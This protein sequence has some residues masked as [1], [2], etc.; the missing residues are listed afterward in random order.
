[1]LGKVCRPVQTFHLNFIKVTSKKTN[2]SFLQ[3]IICLFP[4]PLISLLS[5]SANFSTLSVF[6]SSDLPL[7][8]G[9]VVQ[10]AALTGRKSHERGEA[11]K[12]DCVGI[13]YTWILLFHDLIECELNKFSVHYKPSI[14]KE[15]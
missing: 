14:S 12:L 1:M 8:Q 15:I 6:T 13:V 4:L 9:N 7:T 5:S 11:I 10:K 3:M 2:T